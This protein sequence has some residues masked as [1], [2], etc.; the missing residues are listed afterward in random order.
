MADQELKAE[1]TAV[2]EDLVALRDDL[3]GI[4]ST[5]VSRGKRSAVSAGETIS[6]GVE[7]GIG[8]AREYV[9][10]RPLTMMLAAFAVGL[11]AGKLMN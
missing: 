7:S 5:L 11:I 10:D 6:D 2:K 3:Q 9:E 4:A 8:H 1:L